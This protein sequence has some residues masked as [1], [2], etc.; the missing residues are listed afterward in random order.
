M[1]PSLRSQRAWS[2]AFVWVVC[3]LGLGA[4]CA[5]PTAATLSIPLRVDYELLENVPRQP[6]DYETQVRPILESRCVVCH[7]CYDAPCQLKLSSYEG[8]ARGGSKEVVYDGSRISAADPT[9]LFIDALTTSEWRTKGFHPVVS[10]GVEDPYERLDGSVMYRMLRL[11]Q[12]HPQP[13]TGRLAPG[14][15]V[16]LDRKASCPTLAEFDDYASE[17]PQQGMPFALPNLT[18]EQ[19]Q[20]LVHW[21]AQGAPRQASAALDTRW[22]EQ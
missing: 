13:L 3:T 14:I 8:V 12:L 19:Y 15:D 2:A 9:R 1:A 6:I 11:K 16:G 18:A 17:H 7:G 4:A 22:A 21:I 20:T 10:E 5:T